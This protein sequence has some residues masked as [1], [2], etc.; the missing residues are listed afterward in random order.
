MSVKYRVRLKN[1]RVIGPFSAEE[2]GELFLKG[3]IE[4]TEMCQ[5]FPIGDWKSVNLF[6]NIS[7]IFKKIQEKNLNRIIL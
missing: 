7:E 4:G 1:E 3:H 6:S 2:I 5:Q